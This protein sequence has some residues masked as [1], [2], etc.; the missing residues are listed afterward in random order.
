MFFPKLKEG[1]R[2]GIR[3]LIGKPGANCREGFECRVGWV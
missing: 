1:I 3:W 2:F